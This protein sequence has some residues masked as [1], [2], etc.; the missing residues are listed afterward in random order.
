MLCLKIQILRLSANELGHWAGLVGE[1]MQAAPVCGVT[2]H[3]TNTVRTREEGGR[4]KEDH[5]KSGK[6]Y[7]YLFECEGHDFRISQQKSMVGHSMWLVRE[8]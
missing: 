1:R 5:T 3:L 4:V 2:K 7:Y 6:R 8:S